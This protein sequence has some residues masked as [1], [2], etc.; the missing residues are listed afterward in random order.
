MK[1]E[2][3]RGTDRAKSAIGGIANLP[4][5]QV[6]LALEESHHGGALVSAVRG[7]GDAAAQSV[8]APAAV[9][10]ADPSLPRQGR[11]GVC[12]AKRVTNGAAGPM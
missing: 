7:L 11:G 8:L 3:G 10:H 5:H 2:A 6:A 1:G 9:V 12:H 4:G